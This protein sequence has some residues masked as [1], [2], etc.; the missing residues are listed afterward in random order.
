[1]LRHFLKYT[2]LMLMAIPSLA[3]AHPH[4]WVEMRTDVVFNAA[5]L[6]EGVNVEW[7]FD[8]VY[9]AEALDGMDAN[10]DGEYTQDELIPLTKENLE[11]LKDYGYFT[12]MRAG[13]QLLPAAPPANEGQTYNGSKLQLHFKVPLQAPYDPRKGEFM[14]KIYDP[15]FYIAFDYAK[16]QPVDTTGSLPPNCELTIKPVPPDAETNQMLTMLSTK[17]KDWKPENGEDFGSVFAQPVNI[18]CKS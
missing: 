7:T 10:G 6:I 5:G 9:A 4:V 2:P 13:G 16:E 11:A 15:E 8:D 1:M 14:V 12:Y 18:T 3:N 17:D